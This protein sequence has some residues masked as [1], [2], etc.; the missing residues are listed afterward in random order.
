MTKYF[1][2]KYGIYHNYFY[3]NIMF[4]HISHGS[5]WTVYNSDNFDNF[6]FVMIH[7]DDRDPVLLVN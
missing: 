2:I 5:F 6:E 3:G 7:E 4:G 1:N